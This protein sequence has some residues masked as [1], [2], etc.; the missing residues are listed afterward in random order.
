MIKTVLAILNLKLHARI[1]HVTT[2]ITT[3]EEIL[4]TLFPIV[5]HDPRET[6]RHTTTWDLGKSAINGKT[7]NDPT[8]AASSFPEE[9][10]VKF[11]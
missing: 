1:P 5:V 8:V 4:I 11:R 10:R 6:I 2:T 3:N 7:E 9:K